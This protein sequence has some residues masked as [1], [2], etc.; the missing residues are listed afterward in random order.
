MVDTSRP[1]LRVVAPED[2]AAR[3][4]ADATAAAEAAAP[5]QLALDGL[6]GHIRTRYEQFSKHRKGAAG[7][8]DR[9]LSAMRTFKG[10]YDP[11]RLAEIK[12][13][14]G[15][16]VYARLVSVKCRGATALLRR[17]MLVYGVGGVLL[18]FAAIKLIDLLLAAVIGA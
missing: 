6:A 3:E 10:E 7:W 18:P 15:S 16:E 12:Q 9:L 14:A 13:F 4:E 8:D 5:S 2:L 17:N 11:G 1:L